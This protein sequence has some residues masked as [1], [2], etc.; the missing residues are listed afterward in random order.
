MSQGERWKP[1]AGFADLYEVSDQGRVRSLR[2]GKLM[3]IVCDSY[4]HLRL[5]RDGKATTIKVHREVLHAFV[6][7]AP[8]GTEGCH[9]NGNSLDNRLTNLRWD[10]SKGNHADRARHGTVL[11]GEQ[12]IGSKLTADRV[13]AI[14]AALAKKEPQRLIAERFGICQSAVSFINTRRNWK[15]LGGAQ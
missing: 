7:A 9:T 13:L 2:T 8:A 10:T 1:I 14:R 6:G 5:S 11:K 15:H 3:K 12:V 4:A